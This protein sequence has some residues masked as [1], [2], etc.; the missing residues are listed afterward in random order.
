[1]I[2]STH[3]N[4]IELLKAIGELYIGEGFHLDPCYNKGTIHKGLKDPELKSDL[5]TQYGVFQADCRALLIK[6]NSIRSI[7]FDPPF[8]AGGGA[9]G[10]MAGRYSSYKTVDDLLK[11]YADSM[12]EFDR[13]LKPNG[14]LVFKC[15]DMCN[16]RT[17]TFSHCEIYKMA[18][19]LNFYG[20]DLFILITKNR[21]KPMNMKVQVHARKHHTYFW[22]FQ[23]SNK[24]N[25]VFG[26]SVG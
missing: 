19:E 21:P 3:E 18:L 2:K 9:T 22:V 13:V 20:R 12:K 6:E 23:K 8:L 15:Q 14:Y 10:K 1:M 25:K 4:Q 24:N 26:V 5:D 7:M 17:Q 11:F 16:G